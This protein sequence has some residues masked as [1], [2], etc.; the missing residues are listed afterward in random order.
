MR[1]TLAVLAALLVG[2]APASAAVPG[3]SSGAAKDVADTSATLTGTV[4]PKGQPTSYYFQYGTTTNYG[5]QTANTSAGNANKATA[6]SAA[7]SG[8]KPTTSYHYRLVAYSPEGTTRGGDRT[9]RTTKVPVTLTIDASPNPVLF[10]GPV[11]VSGVVGGRPPNTPI[12]L[13]RNAFPFTTG[14][15]DYGNPQVTN[16]NGQYSFPVLD[17]TSTTQFRV[18]TT[19][20]KPTAFSQVATEAVAIN[21]SVRTRVRRS[22]GR[23]HV[24]LTGVVKPAHEA[25]PL[26]VQK[27]KNGKWITVKGGVTRH[28][29]ASSS[30]YS[31][32]MTLRRGGLYRVFV[33]VAD[34]DHTNGVSPEFT[35]RA[36][37]R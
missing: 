31:V 36:K 15:A 5:A 13:Q 10:G 9:F 22:G 17:V 29:S 35:I 1:I 34:G 7:V 12:V 18:R 6:V 2:A 28:A 23:A 30:G 4:N 33:R 21:V 11:T 8:L 20:E 26:A 32:K 24:L 3:A 16:A 25:T 37:P 14:F 19:E 27:R